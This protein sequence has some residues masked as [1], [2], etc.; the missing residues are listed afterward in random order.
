MIEP[1]QD[2]KKLEEI[3]SK[4]SRYAAAAY[5]FTRHAVTYASH[6][7]FAHG[8]HVSGRDLL[9]A[10]RR[11]ALDRFGLLAEDVLASWGLRSTEDFG[12]IVFHLV[13]AGLLAKTDED[14][15]EDFRGVYTFGDAFGADAAWKEIVETLQPSPPRPVKRTGREDETP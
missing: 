9:E 2:A 5:D 6:V 10:I 1:D 3:L 15:L 14:T 7:L 4:D 8:K 13:D 11:V 12:E